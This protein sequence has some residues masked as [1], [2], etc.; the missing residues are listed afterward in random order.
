MTGQSRWLSFLEA[1][2]GNVAGFLLAVGINWL[3]LP[4]FGFDVRMDQAFGITAIFASISIA[5]IYIWR[6]AFNYYEMH[7]G[8]F[9][10]VGV[11]LVL[12]LWWIMPRRAKLWAFMNDGRTD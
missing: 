9:Y 1:A 3:I 11:S 8:D 10:K 5:R 12:R 2:S 7:R 6:R 4:W